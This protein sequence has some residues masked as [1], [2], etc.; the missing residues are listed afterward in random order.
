[1][2]RR[3]SI[4]GCVCPSVRPS[5][6]PS[7]RN[8]FSQTTARRILRR[9]FG[10]VPFASLSLF[11]LYFYRWLM[12]INQ[13]NNKCVSLY[14]VFIFVFIAS[15]SFRIIEKPNASLCWCKYI[16]NFNQLYINPILIFL[17]VLPHPSDIAWTC[18][19]CMHSRTSRMLWC[20]PARAVCT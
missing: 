20:S 14:F 1:M 5:V 3:I 2:R 4:R 11:S 12:S 18:V 9:V 19:R 10:L 8:A 7:V 17:F 16:R 6:G 15:T 13:S